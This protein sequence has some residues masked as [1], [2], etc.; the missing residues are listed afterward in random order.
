MKQNGAKKKLRLYFQSFACKLLNKLS[1]WISPEAPTDCVGSC[2]QPHHGLVRK[3]SWRCRK[4]GRV[5]NE[6]VLRNNPPYACPC[7]GTLYSYVLLV[8]PEEP[9]TIMGHLMRD[10]WSPCETFSMHRKA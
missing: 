7:C 3:D 9:E 2:W 1:N 4:C 10:G 8:F 6:Y 5:T